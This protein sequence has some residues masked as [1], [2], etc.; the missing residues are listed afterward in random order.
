MSPTATDTTEALDESS[1]LYRTSWRLPVAIGAEGIYL[2]LEDGRRVIDAVGGA[3]VACIGNNHPVVQD[4]IKAQLD[5][6]SCD[7]QLSCH[8]WSSILT[9]YPR[10]IQYAAIKP[11]GRS[12]GKIPDHRQQGRL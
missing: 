5:K 9:P 1:I 10:C 12:A 4:A 7:Y 6:V 11:A 8:R 2:D 3:A